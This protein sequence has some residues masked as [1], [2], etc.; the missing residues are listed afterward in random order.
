MVQKKIVYSLFV[1]HSKDVVLL[2]EGRIQGQGLE[3]GAPGLREQ[4]R[5]VLRVQ[6]ARPTSLWFQGLVVAIVNINA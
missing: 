3:A 4:V 1:G 2:G 6:A 5:G